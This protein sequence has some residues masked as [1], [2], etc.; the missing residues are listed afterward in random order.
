[1]NHEFFIP[2]R[3]AR[4]RAAWVGLALVIAS[5]AAATTVAITEPM[6]QKQPRAASLLDRLRDDAAL[7]NTEASRFLLRQ[8]LDNYDRGRDEA[9]L[10]EAAMWFDR[11]W[12]TPE[13]LSSGLSARL[14]ERQ[15]N[16]PV[17][18][19]HWLCALGE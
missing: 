16:H 10:Y 19:W 18:R 8:L 14:I 3:L 17:L 1:M 11:D 6:Q 7:G 13:Y 12:S 2:K 5:F 4:R 15:C 9:V